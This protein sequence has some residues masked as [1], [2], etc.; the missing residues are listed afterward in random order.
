M[1]STD[2]YTI[3][4]SK[5]HN[6]HYLKRYIKFIDWC[7]EQNKTLDCTVYTEEHHIAPKAKDLFPEYSEF[8][9]AHT[10]N[11]AALTNR[12]HIIAHVMLWKTFKGSQT[13]ALDYILN[14]F[15][16]T[17][18]SS[19]LSE[20]RIPA[21]IRIRYAAT[22]KEEARL[23]SIGMSTYKDAEG[24]NYYLHRD[25]SRIQELDLAHIKTGTTHSASAKVRMSASKWWMKTVPMYFLNCRTHVRIYSDKFDKYLAQG[26]TTELSQTDNDYTAQISSSKK[27]EKMKG[28]SKWAL[29]D[30]TFYKFTTRDD[31]EIAQLGLIQ[32][33]TDNVKE[34]RKTLS[35][36]AVKVNAGSQFYNDGKVCKKFKIDPG[37]P[38]VLGQLTR[39]R[40]A[41]KAACS[42]R[43]GKLS[44]H[45]GI[46]TTYATECPGDGWERGM[47]PRQ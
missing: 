21:A 34:Q 43:K 15:N 25:D 5:P 45:N 7:K 35:T 42:K 11:K 6:I 28:R 2:I 33:V 8:N 30:G 44:W 38:W 31:P 3:L 16:A 1:T 40:S 24:N 4:S 39:D 46:T 20:R 10:W 14:R 26:W 13:Q 36:S 9:H 37:A 18:N 29:P 27:T 41:Q 17:T 23:L 47:A 12:Q 19:S 32:Y 22:I